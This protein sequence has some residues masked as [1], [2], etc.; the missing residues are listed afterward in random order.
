MRFAL[1][2]VAAGFIF[3]IAQPA[4]AA[5]FE[6]S[7]WIPYWRVATGTLDVAPHLSQLTT[8][9]PFSYEVT[10]DG[11]IVDRANMDNISA[12][13]FLAQA[14]AAN[15]RVVPSILWT[16][17]VAMQKILS[18]QTTR[19][20]L[21]DAIANLVKEKGYDGIDIDF[22]A[23]LAETRNYFSTFLR[24]LYSRMGPKWVY[25]AIEPRTPISSLY[26]G[27][28]PKGAGIYANDYVEINKY[29]DRVEIM[30]YDQGG[31]DAVLNKARTA[32]YIPLSDPGWVAKVVQETLKT[33]PA[34]KIVLGIP[35]YGY[36]YAVTPA[37][38]GYKYDLQ[39]AF[40]PRYGVDLAGQLG[41]PPARTSSGELSLIYKPASTTPA[42]VSTSVDTNTGGAAFAPAV[43]LYAPATIAAQVA[44][45]F[46]IL[47]WSDAQ[48]VSDKVALAKKM[49]LKGVA[50]FKFD[51]GEDQ[52]IWSVLK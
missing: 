2:G 15:V 42:A 47:W 11:T 3:L 10:A 18:N 9:N 49:G 14:K 12:Q 51:G 28:P 4:H 36:E 43:T 30:A 17:G 16:D 46:N 23:K 7:G 45:P 33:I 24:G 48:A 20:A 5:G 50:I 31:A 35:T 8:I 34:R 44:P 40:N 21:E 19:I 27:T 26:L 39:W 37:E 52:N 32:P 22:E 38:Q 13:A 1:A 41:I 29:S 6:Y 25:C